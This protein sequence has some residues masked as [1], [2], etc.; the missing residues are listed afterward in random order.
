MDGGREKRRKNA[1][2]R[3]QRKKADF[4]AWALKEGKTRVSAAERLFQEEEECSF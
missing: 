3:S 1:K 2:K 4:L